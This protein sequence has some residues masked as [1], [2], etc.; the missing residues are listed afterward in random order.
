MG[1]KKETER[2]IR[3]LEMVKSEMA[4]QIAENHVRCTQAIIEAIRNEFGEAEKLV[5]AATFSLGKIGDKSV[6]I[7]HMEEEYMIN[8][9][10]C[11]VSKFD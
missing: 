8:A 7:Q 3:T 9:P 5:R 6:E 10:E 1:K 11:I 4:Y 2:N